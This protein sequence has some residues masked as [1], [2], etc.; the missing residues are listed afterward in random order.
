MRLPSLKRILAAS[1]VLAATMPAFA[2][3]CKTQAALTEAERAP[4]VE[5]A[6]QIAADVQGGRPAELKA[7]TVPSVAAN[8][9][10]IQQSATALTPL[11]NGSTLTVDAVYRLDAADAKAG[12]DQTQF[13]CDAADNRTHVTLGIQHLPPGQYA[14]AIVHAT[15]GAKPQQLGL[16]LETTAPAGPWQLAGFFPK[17]LTVAGRDGLWYWKQARVY[18]QQKQGWNAWFYYSTA[19]YLLQPAGFFSSTNLEKL[20]DE[21]QARRPSGLPGEIP[22]TIKADG[23]D[24]AISSLRTDDA[25]GGLD[26]VVHYDAAEGA[27]PV[28]ARAHATAVMKALLALHPELREAFHGM[29]AF[30][31]SKTGSA[32]SLE[33]PMRDLTAT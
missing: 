23:A 32:F 26:L 24:V 30:A 18:A 11:L 12:E 5:A 31:D 27:D 33:L 2:V 29:W 16:L 4:I 28:A 10:V 17:P 3:S 8:F 19:A 7:A 6:R 15:G 1:V 20:N 22:L 25:L 14:F 21:Q 9:T 13:F